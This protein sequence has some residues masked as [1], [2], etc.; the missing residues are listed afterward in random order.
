M[1][2]STPTVPKAKLAAAPSPHRIQKAVQCATETVAPC[3][4]LKD[5]VAVNPFLGLSDRTFSQAA[6]TLAGAA[7]AQM[8]MPRSFYAEAISSGR[9]DTEDLV[10]ALALEP[11]AARLVGDLHGLRIAILRDDTCHHPELLPTVSAIAADC[12]G[13]NWTD[14]VTEL[15]SRW[16]ARYFDQG[17]ALLASPFRNLTPYAA[18]R[19]EATHDRTPALLGLSS[20]RGA[21]AFLPES[22][23]E[24]IAHAV[25][26]LGI[27]EEAMEPY[28]HR[29]LMTHSGW[30]AYARY[31]DWQRNLNGQRPEILADLLAVRL[32]WELVLYTGLA[33]QGIQDAWGEARSALSP[34]SEVSTSAFAAEVVLQ[35]AY[36]LGWQKRLMASFTPQ[37]NRR[38]AERPAVQ[39]AFCID[40]RSEVYRRRLE[41]TGRDI[42]TIGFAGF[43]GIPMAYRSLSQE[44]D[45]PQCPAL[46]A[47]QFTIREALLDA[48]PADERSA[49]NQ[50]NALRRSQA[51]WK[52]FKLGAVASFGFVETLGIALALKLITDS[53]GLTRPVPH[54]ATANVPA[55]LHG[56]LAPRLAPECH[57]GCETGLDM[58]TRVE[59][60]ARVL[61]AMGLTE[62]FA[63]LV[64][65]VGH[66]STSVNNPHAAGL[67]CGACGGHSG[68]SNV[69]VLT[70]ILNDP[71]VRAA[72]LDRGIAMPP[73]TVF[74][75]GNHDT[76][77][78]T[79]S[80]FDLT[81]VPESHA[82]DL[83]ELQ[84]RLEKASRRV[85][86]E[87][88]PRLGLADKPALEDALSMRGRDWSQVRPEWGLA[89]CAS[90]I[91]APRHRTRDLDLGGRAFL[92]NYDWRQDEDYAV[93][94][95]VMTAPLV[96]A[97][98]I[99]LQYYG[100]TVDNR[101]F[102]SGNKTLL[103]VVGALGVLEGN[104]GDLR[105]GLPWQSLHDGQRLM[106]D[107]L[108]LTAIIDAPV[109]AINTIIEKHESLRN[110]LDNGWLHL[111]AMD[112]RGAVRQHYVGIGRWEEVKVTE[113]LRVVAA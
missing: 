86:R 23:V 28:F 109:E 101:V 50:R 61:K 52:A 30:S 33:P 79:V 107:P 78:D 64:L 55:A 73:D 113:G 87:R 11:E 80:L 72:L 58:P 60:A 92:H 63:R 31:L 27:P 69:R 68:E 6:E 10:N 13:V 12:T 57:D 5:F 17:Q 3:W 76:T 22:A 85:R 25:Q 66:G 14:H 89:G 1:I 7:G 84:A 43:F 88:A 108:R 96:V 94:E 38:T 100:S 16:A 93:L 32:A 62:N 103:N 53:L 77:T 110:L 37:S 99:N 29:L 15:L 82:V 65:L 67:D 18:W 81:A 106:H 83:Q 102:G 45:R 105:V 26:V 98:W 19:A 24:L 91:A 41:A 74:L 36:E 46:L 40:V 111:Y 51:A 47:P 4:P 75:G 71:Q 59:L 48:T 2:A 39:A 97:S 44:T 54:P 49:L 112:S 90:F 21:V 35:R 9:I 70:T 95:L 8:F 104:G 34:K 56:R 42:E 20:F